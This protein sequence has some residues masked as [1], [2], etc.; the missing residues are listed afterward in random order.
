MPFTSTQGAGAVRIGNRQL[1]GLGL[2]SAGTL[3]LEIVMTRIF[4]VTMGYHFA[5]LAI[6]LALM[7]S[8]T[9]GVFLYWRPGLLQPG[10]AQPAIAR[11]T[12]LLAL[13]AP[14]S[15]ALYL[16][17]PFA[18]TLADGNWLQPLEF[19]WLAVIFLDLA[20]P[21]F[22]SG[23]VLTLALTAWALDAGRVY[24]ADLSGAAVGCLLSIA[25]LELLGGAGAVLAIAGVLALAS[26]A[27]LFDGAAGQR[28]RRLAFGGM[29]L[30]LLLSALQV[31]QPW[32]V[33]R[34]E[35]A[36]R[37]LEYEQ[38][39]ANSQVTV[40]EPVNYPFF[41][42][43]S[44]SMWDHT[45]GEGGSFPHAL[46]LLDAV[47][48]TPIQK[49]DGDL[50]QV[51][52]LHYD[53]TSMVYHL[54]DA[55]ETLVIGPGGGRDVLAALVAGAP[56]VTAVEV[57]PA[58]VEAV[59]GPFND[60][61]GGLYERPDVSVV[62][63]DARGYVERTEAVY[64][65]IQASLIDT[66]AAD[67]SNAFALSE[68][69]LYTIEAF[70]TYYQHLSE[71][72]ILSISRWYL[73]GQPAETLRLVATGMAGWEAAGVGDPA[74]H[75]AVVVHSRSNAP[76]EGLST[77]LFSKQPFSAAQ[78]EALQQAT[79]E[80]GYEVAYAP[81]LPGTEEVGTFILEPN[82]AD[83]IANYPLDISPATDDRPYFFNLVRAGDLF[84]TF[85]SGSGMQRTSRESIV[86]LFAV[87]TIALAATLL[88]ILLPLWL[89]SRK[90]DLG[91]PAPLLLLY[92]GALGLGFMLVEIPIIARLTV[93]LG[94]PVYSLA[95][96]LFSRL[97]FSGLG[98][99]WSG[100]QLA[101]RDTFWL[102]RIF[103][104]LAVVILLHATVVVPLL[105]ATLGFSLA[106][107]LL[108]TVGILAVPG[109]LLGMPFPTGIR[110]AGQKNSA[111]IPWLWAINGVTSVIGSALAVTVS[112]HIGFRLTLV[113]AAAIYVVA[114]LLLAA[115]L[116]AVSW[117]TRPLGGGGKAPRGAG[118]LSL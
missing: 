15:L 55:P 83:F 41:W 13:S 94:R 21:F 24:W 117:R 75:I 115:E 85:L 72:G 14:A 84:D 23:L 43:I 71:R 16:Q 27:L 2:V 86:I 103:P 52:F 38:W 97:L 95:V 101:R 73:P 60:F 56:Q 80:L 116:G 28:H 64:D 57:N 88:F 82:K 118:N 53:V 61:A 47:A 100:R 70:S 18:P 7:G 34:P 51:R 50:N 99:L 11:L 22:F 105:Q 109:F 31:W 65:V 17:I 68:N 5:F 108:L 49:F 62:V 59:R 112:I 90:A 37:A 76:G 110:Y 63:A 67:G 77:T 12:L 69:S 87:I 107:R 6:S 42:S 36:D 45:I 29:A 104:L 4:S 48:G 58:V 96:V 35:I 25:V 78:V 30:V 81:G 66:L 20:I 93:Y 46:L 10:R 54:L 3:A 79:A 111:I 74:Q 39:S 92:F 19:F 106:G 91:E 8:A 1:L 40:Y 113:V 114:G 26:L 89:R 9:A 44:P 32:L 98:S 102:L 33:I